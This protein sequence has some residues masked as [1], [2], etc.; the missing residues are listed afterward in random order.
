MGIVVGK[1]ED[2]LWVVRPSRRAPYQHPARPAIGLAPVSSPNSNFLGPLS[3]GPI[4]QLFC[5]SPTGSKEKCLIDLVS[6]SRRRPQIVLPL[7]INPRTGKGWTDAEE[8]IISQ[9]MLM[10]ACP[11][12]TAIQRAR[13]R[14]L[15]GETDGTTACWQ[16]PAAIPAV[17]ATPASP[18]VQDMAPSTSQNQ[19]AAPSSHNPVT[20]R[21]AS[22]ANGQSA[23]SPIN[24]HE[25]PTAH[26]V[27]EVVPKVRAKAGRRR[28]W[29]SDAE[30]KATVRE[31]QK[32]LTLPPLPDGVY[33]ARE[34]VTAKSSPSSTARRN[35]HA[36]LQENRCFFCERLFGAYVQKNLAKPEQLH[37]EDEHFIPRRLPGSRKDEN[38]HAV[39]HICNRLKSD[40]VFNTEEQCRS[41]LAEAW[42]LNGYQEVGVHAIHYLGENHSV[43]FEERVAAKACQTV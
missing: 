19:F 43:L 42:Q 38:R 10:E 33:R 40:L 25:A 21:P 39:C 23:V 8:H 18:V 5:G 11:R 1:T 20:D 17:A 29:K 32:P 36:G 35:Y 14:R 12:I 24:G 34:V 4:R 22:P 30:R 2:P 7:V 26:A 27:T 37:A 9:I 3:A 16:L 41:W 31:Q 6:T 28:K 15:I 13:S